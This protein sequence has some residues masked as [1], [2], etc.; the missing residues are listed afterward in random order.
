M[1]IYITPLRV[2]QQSL[3]S[4]KGRQ[5]YIAVFSISP[6]IQAFPFR[7]TFSIHPFSGLNLQPF[8][9]YILLAIIINELTTAVMMMQQIR[10]SIPPLL[11]YHPLGHHHR[12]LTNSG[13]HAVCIMSFCQPLSYRHHRHYHRYQPRLCIMTP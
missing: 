3:T 6:S 1:N 13:V 9:S 10:S 11:C 2:E 12:Q 8:S 7:N 5:A 4:K